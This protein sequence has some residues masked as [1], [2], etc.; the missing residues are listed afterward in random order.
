MS[1]GSR[2][3]YLGNKPTPFSE[4]SLSSVLEMSL[5]Y[6]VAEMSSEQRKWEMSSGR[7]FYEREIISF[8]YERSSKFLLAPKQKI[9]GLGY[10]LGSLC[11][12]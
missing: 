6:E 11:S 7:Y 4:I 10:G 8:R 12:R 3:P 2:D 9:V 1:S 5:I